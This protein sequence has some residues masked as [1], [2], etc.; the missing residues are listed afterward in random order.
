MKKM[1]EL[2]S[3][4]TTDILVVRFEENFLLLSETG[5]GGIKN[6]SQSNGSVTDD[7]DGWI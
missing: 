2:Y 3:S 7:S 1:K 6:M 4:P 5:K